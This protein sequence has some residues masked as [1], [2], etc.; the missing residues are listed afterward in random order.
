MNQAIAFVVMSMLVRNSFS[1]CKTKY[2]EQALMREY[3]KKDSKRYLGSGSFGKVFEFKLGDV[4]YA[5]KEVSVQIKAKSLQSF[6][7]MHCG[8]D[9][10]K[11]D[12]A[13]WV[14]PQ[15]NKLLTDNPDMYKKERKE[16][17]NLF[18]VL[19]DK[20]KGIDRPQFVVNLAIAYFAK[21]KLYLEHLE[22][23]I[24]INEL[25]SPEEQDKPKLI[26]YKFH[27][28]VQMDGLN[29]ILF[30]EKNEYSMSS[31]D[32]L[33][34]LVRWSIIERLHFYVSLLRQVQDLHDFEVV[35]CDLKEDNIMIK[36]KF[37][38]KATM[39]DYGISETSAFCNGGTPGYQP[40]E[41]YRTI[42]EK[43]NEGGL[44]FK[45][46]VFAMGVVI[47]NL[48]IK[49]AIFDSDLASSIRAIAANNKSDFPKKEELVFEAVDLLLGVSGGLK[50]SKDDTKIVKNN[51]DY[52]NLKF[53]ECIRE[54]LRFDMTKRW[55]SRKAYLK[56][57]ELFQ[58]SRFLYNPEDQFQAVVR[59]FNLYLEYLYPLT[60]KL[61]KLPGD[62]FKI[63]SLRTASLQ[64][65][66]S[67]SSYLAPIQSLKII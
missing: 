9:K 27:F 67:S 5:A 51:I 1:F 56:F 15:V 49:R 41:M 53:L 21:M 12:D 36:S 32:F 16:F 14:I 37:S 42:A 50:P 19:K 11:L 40:P 55:N 60:E 17:G 35:H 45:A 4:T 3:Q 61:S 18:E 58:L 57:W 20:D 59:Q 66:E 8:T 48:E 29:Y 63:A 64:K 39:I 65:K 44:R 54:M 7:E 23:E 6:K 31:N 28:C 13:D 34:R 25:I 30:Q 38:R 26:N 24:L 62:E 46:D 2:A 33:V 43:P 52:L 47:A 10:D 22:K